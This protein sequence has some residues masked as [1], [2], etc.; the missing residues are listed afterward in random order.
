M[1][2]GP[3]LR[4]QLDG[5]WHR[6]KQKCQEMLDLLF[7]RRPS[8]SFNTLGFSFLL[9]EMGILPFLCILHEATGKTTSNLT[10]LS[11]QVKIKILLLEG[12][13]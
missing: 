4:D 2:Q 6:I 3:G 1:T 12:A 13:L 11:L 5:R 9:Y 7:D 10:V 8:A